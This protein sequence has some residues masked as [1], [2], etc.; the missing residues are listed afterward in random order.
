MKHYHDNDDMAVICP[1][2]GWEG[3]LAESDDMDGYDGDT[4]S[5]GELHAV[6]PKCATDV[7][8]AE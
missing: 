1:S 5:Y 3:T 7:E 6:C 4:D 2:C 8:A